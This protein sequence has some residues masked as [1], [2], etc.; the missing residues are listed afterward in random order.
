VKKPSLSGGNLVKPFWCRL[1]AFLRD[2]LPNFAFI[3]DISTIL[4]E[5]SNFIGMLRKT[6][7]I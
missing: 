4:A 3:G 1:F 6:C 7:R 5:Y 2:L